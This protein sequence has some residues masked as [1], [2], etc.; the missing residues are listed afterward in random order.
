[1]LS[2][3]AYRGESIAV[4]AC[5]NTVFACGLAQDA[6][7]N[8][9]NASMTF[10]VSEPFA[11]NLQMLPNSSGGCDVQGSNCVPLNIATNSTSFSTIPSPT[12]PLVVP[13]STQCTRSDSKDVALG[14]GLGVPLILLLLAVAVLS[15]MLRR[16]QRE[17]R[18][19]ASIQRTAALKVQR[20]E[21]R[22]DGE[23]HNMNG[24]AE[25]PATAERRELP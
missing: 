3:V 13:S 23:N 4:S 22:G 16:A 20:G 14:V 7:Q 17:Y 19:L 6:A 12:S 15:A 10:R 9:N 21:D 5:S 2:R 25:L 11:M 8:C 18:N 24:R 1:M